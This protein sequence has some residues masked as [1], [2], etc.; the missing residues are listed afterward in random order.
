[1]E[2]VVGLALLGMLLLGLATVVHQHGR[3]THSLEAQRVGVRA[4]E[5]ALSQLHAG[6]R[7]SL[8][9][10]DMQIELRAATTP[11][12]PPPDGYTWAVVT[13]EYRKTQA[14]L[15][16][17]ARRKAFEETLGRQKEAPR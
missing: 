8:D 12:T 6:N 5:Y 3:A 14:C 13:V 9:L 2:T 10:P 7:V 11:I 1:M 4:A 16:G 15:V 17:L